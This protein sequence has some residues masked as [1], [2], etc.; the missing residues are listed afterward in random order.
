MHDA[1]LVARI[2]PLGEPPSE[3]L[4]RRIAPEEGGQQHAELRIRE[5]KLVT[6]KRSGGREIAAVHVIYECSDREQ[7]DDANA[8]AGRR[9]LRDGGVIPRFHTDG[10]RD[11]AP[12][13]ATKGTTVCAVATSA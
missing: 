1:A 7:H 9:G 2:S 4:G 11:H 5:R 3:Q 8:D 12:T 6:N 10:R 13:S